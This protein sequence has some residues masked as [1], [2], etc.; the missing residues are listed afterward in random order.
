MKTIH[1]D[2]LVFRQ[3]VKCSADRDSLVSLFTDAETMKYVG[4]GASSEEKADETFRRLFTN[5]Y[6]IS[7]FDIWCIFTRAAGEYI[8][9][10]ELKP[11]KGTED[12]EISYILKQE[13]RGNGYASEIARAL[14]GYGFEERGLKRIIATVNAENENSIRVLETLGTDLEK[15]KDEHSEIFIYSINRSES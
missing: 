6:E 4:E 12:W 9:H 3:Y 7:A 11:Y 14:V 15:E 5:V 8:G 2:R 1:T 10:A 13:H